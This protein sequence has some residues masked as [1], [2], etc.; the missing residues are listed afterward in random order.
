MIPDSQIATELK[1]PEGVVHAIRLKRW[2]VL[3]GFAQ[4]KW[5]EDGF[6]ALKRWGGA[7]DRILEMYA[8]LFGH[9]AFK[10]GTKDWTIQE[11][12]KSIAIWIDRIGNLAPIIKDM[13]AA[14]LNGD[15]PRSINW[16]IFRA[17]GQ[18]CRW[19]MLWLDLMNRRAEAE[20]QAELKWHPDE[21]TPQEVKDFL[22]AGHTPVT[23][24]WV[25]EAK[26]RLKV[27]SKFIQEGDANPAMRREWNEI[28]LRLKEH[29]Y[30][31]EKEM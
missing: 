10:A 16:F 15:K 31:D 8:D 11:T 21:N 29:G 2:S 1:I 25:S 14:K 26:A 22:K 12:R 30:L 3:R 5:N 27:L 9:T 6:V 24:T 17:D 23:P 13:E 7:V 20:K 19:E 18:A 4:K 28:Q